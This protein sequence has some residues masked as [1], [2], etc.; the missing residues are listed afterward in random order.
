LTGRLLPAVL[1]AVVLLGTIALLDFLVYLSLD[2][3]TSDVASFTAA[4]FGAI[5]LAWATGAFGLW[6]SSKLT[7][8]GIRTRL[9][10]PVLVTVVTA[11]VSIVVTAE[12]MFISNHDLLLLVFLLLFAVVVAF[13]VALIA[14]R[15]LSLPVERLAGAAQQMAAGNLDARV[16]AEG[17]DELARLASTF[18]EMAGQLAVS[19]RERAFMERA[20]KDLLAGV[21]HDLRTPLASIRAMV[22][23]ITDGVVDEP[24]SRRYLENVLN[25]TARLGALIDDLFELSQI[26][27]GALRLDFV[28]TKVAGI[29]SEAVSSME[30]QARARGIHFESQLPE[31]DARVVADPPRLQRA[32]YNLIHNA[33][34]H[35]PSDGTVMLAAASTPDEVVISVSDTGEGI[36][37]QDLPFV[38]DRFWRGDP[39][40]HEDGVGLGLAISKSIVEAHR[41]RIWAESM[42]G[43]GSRFSLALPRMPRP[44]S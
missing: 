1:F 14:A 10:L 43:K 29:I 8:N 25:E 4:M 18:N 7:A 11:L 17:A 42:P 38:F 2:A 32:L 6:A 23:A 30:P 31:N 35:T 34:R 19:A 3:S 40:R 5:L 15:T 26:D 37:E 24:T 21:S 22:E 12:L 27:T 39:S 20:R 41:G 16:Q 9:L 13:P 36:P 28:E 33:L 44:A